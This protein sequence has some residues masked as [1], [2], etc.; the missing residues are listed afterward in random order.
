M[1]ARVRACV[2]ACVYVCVCVCVLMALGDKERDIGLNSGRRTLGLYK[3][4]YDIIT[5]TRKGGLSRNLTVQ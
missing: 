2:R 3:N 1:C 4:V 5:Y